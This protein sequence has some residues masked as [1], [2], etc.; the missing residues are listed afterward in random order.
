MSTCVHAAESTASKPPPKPKEK[1]VKKA[2]D[3]PA[4][5]P[6]VKKTT[7]APK[8][9]ATG[10]LEYCRLFYWENIFISDLRKVS[11][12][13]ALSNNVCLLNILT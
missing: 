7:A 10:T 1:V 11:S 12:A 5:K 4:K 2:A 8:K 9:K 3:G 13:S 6:V